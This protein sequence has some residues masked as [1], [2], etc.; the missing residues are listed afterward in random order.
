MDS[1][2]NVRWVA[3]LGSQTYGNP[4]VA[5]GRVFVGTNNEALYDKEI[6]GDKGILVA[7]DAATGEFLW[8]MVSDKLLSG[9]VNDWPYQGILLSRRW[10]KAT[11]SITWT[12]RGEVLAVDVNGMADGNDGPVTDE[13]LQSPS[14]GG[15]H[16]EVRHDGG[17]RRLPPQHVEREPGRLRKPALRQHLERP[18]RDPRQHPLAAH[19]PRSSRWTKSPGSSSGSRTTSA[20][21]SCTASGRPRGSARWAA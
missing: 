20:K 16:L 3:A 5:G 13:A 7:F 21:T 6:V 4:V 11:V 14:D 12:N 10:W 1:G 18:R 19:R 15:H 17:T 8:Q 9:R 2:R